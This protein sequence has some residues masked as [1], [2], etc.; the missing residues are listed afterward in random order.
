MELDPIPT[1]QKAG[2]CFYDI[3]IGGIVVYPRTVG[4]IRERV[5]ACTQQ[6]YQKP[7]E[8]MSSYH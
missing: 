3:H 7:E 1:L 5:F 6:N 8:K 4:Y 2:L